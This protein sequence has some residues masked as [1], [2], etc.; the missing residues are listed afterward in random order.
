MFLN[1]G[2]D[3]ILILLIIFLSAC[4]NKKEQPQQKAAPPVRVDVIVAHPTVIQNNIEVNGTAVANESAE[5]HPEISGII[6][7]LNVPEGAFISKGTLIARIND[8]DLQA[9]LIKST[10][11]LELAEKTEQRLSKLLEIKGL[12]Q[13]DYDAAVNQVTSIKADIAY[14]QAQINKTYIRAPF[15]GNA[16]LRQVSPGSYITP[17]S[18]IATIQQVNKIKIDFTLPQ[19]YSAFV[20]KGVSVYV[21][22]DVARQQKIKAVVVAAEPQID[23]NTRNLKVRALLQNG[24]INPGAFV[25]VYVNAGT[26]KNSI[27]VPTNAI[28]PDAKNDMLVLMKNGKAAFV[29][30]ETGLRQAATVEITS[31]VNA[32]DTVVVSGVL[33]A[34]PDAPLTIGAV[35][36][37]EDGVV[38]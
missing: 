3:V 20:K 12:N 35:K 23:I 26:D 10:A 7:Y 17:A 25:K 19:E 24:T 33:F 1:K 16:G 34:R 22:A 29:N 14:T 31:G 4:N 15:S 21:V 18:I 38:Q 8:A 11:S 30:I 32:G 6:T 27:L 2:Y 36:K 9:Q 37:L 5:L 28:I 13:A